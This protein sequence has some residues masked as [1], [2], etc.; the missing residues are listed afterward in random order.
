MDDSPRI[1]IIKNAPLVP[2]SSS[3]QA[4]IRTDINTT[5]QYGIGMYNIDGTRK[6]YIFPQHNSSSMSM[7]AIPE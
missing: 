2:S 5:F 7:G 4:R 1:R 3:S 6:N